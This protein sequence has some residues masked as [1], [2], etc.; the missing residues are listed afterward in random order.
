[1]LTNYIK[2]LDFVSDVEIA[3][4]MCTVISAKCAFADFYERG[5][6]D[7]LLHTEDYGDFL[8]KCPGAAEYLEGHEDGED[9]YYTLLNGAYYEGIPAKCIFLCRKIYNLRGCA[10]AIPYCLPKKEANKIFSLGYFKN[11]LS[12]EAAIRTAIDPNFE[13]IDKDNPIYIKGDTAEVYLGEDK[14]YVVP[15]KVLQRYPF[16][17]WWFKGNVLYVGKKLT[18]KEA[19]SNV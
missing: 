6:L 12:L 1:M 5:Y 18:F 10:N 7:T 14:L 17:K 19:C 16:E 9:I 13:V 3:Q 2:G 11:G 8:D 15:T 4:H